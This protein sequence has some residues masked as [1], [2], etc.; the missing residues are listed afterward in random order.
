MAKAK[1]IELYEKKDGPVKATVKKKSI[2]I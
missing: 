1:F 2:N